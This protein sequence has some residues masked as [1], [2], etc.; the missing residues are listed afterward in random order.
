[1]SIPETIPRS[2]AG[3][4]SLHAHLPGGGAVGTAGRSTSPADRASSADGR[5]HASSSRRT[6]ARRACGTSADVRRHDT[7]DFAKDPSAQHLALHRE[8]APLVIRQPQSTPFQL[9]A[10]QAVL[11]QQVLDHRQ[12]ASV[13]PA[14]EELKSNPNRTGSA[15]MARKL[16][17][18]RPR[19]KGARPRGTIA[20]LRATTG[21]LPIPMGQEAPGPTI[22]TG[23]GLQDSESSSLIWLCTNVAGK[24]SD[25]LSVLSLDRFTAGG[26]HVGD[27]RLPIPLPVISPLTFRALH[28][29]PELRIL[30]ISCIMLED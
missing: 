10:Q 12:L 4:V 14:G 1:M 2:S 11:L 23:R 20:W 9:L 27:Q 16:H 22:G 21:F 29:Q 6:S 18:V 8:P 7:G 26:R 30:A 28:V 3:T 17:E 24:S 13:D 19:R 15:F 25:Q 5:G